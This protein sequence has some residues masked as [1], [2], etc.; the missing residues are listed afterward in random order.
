MSMIEREKVIEEIERL[1]EKNNQIGFVVGE[2]GYRV[3]LYD[4][5]KFIAALPA[6]EEKEM[7]IVESS[8]SLMV[9]TSIPK[10]GS[11]RVLIR[12]AKK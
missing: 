3:G 8:G 2:C 1:I 10:A 7:W 6:V 11:N 5:Q 9:L 12:K 4:I